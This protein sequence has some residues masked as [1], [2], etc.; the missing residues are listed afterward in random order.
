MNVRGDRTR[1]HGEFDSHTPL[2]VG[3][4]VTS[5]PVHPARR[6]SFNREGSRE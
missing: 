6:L 3:L 4:G 2:S 1:C 5:F